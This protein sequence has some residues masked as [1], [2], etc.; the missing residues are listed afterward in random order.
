[1]ETTTNPEAIMTSTSH[2][3]IDTAVSY[4]DMANPLRTGIVAQTLIS[5]WGVQYLVRFEDGTETYSDMR[6]RGWKVAA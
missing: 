4:E 3:A 2:I 5:K 1:M 6:Q